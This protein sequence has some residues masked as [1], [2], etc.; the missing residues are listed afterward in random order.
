MAKARLSALTVDEAIDLLFQEDDEGEVENAD[1]IIV[2]PDVDELTDEE[3][4]SE[5]IIGELSVQD[6]PGSLEI[7]KDSVV[8]EKCTTDN[9]KSAS[10]ARK[11][12]Q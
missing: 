11:N 1:I 12:T 4:V 6:V 9:A 8:S 5:D 10:R 7:H 3:D 2:P